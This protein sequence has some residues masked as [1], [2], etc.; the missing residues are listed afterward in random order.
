M[1]ALT[2]Q[3]P[4]LL[5]VIKKSRAKHKR[6]IAAFDADGTLWNTDLGE[7]L[8]RYQVDN[9]LLE[10]LPKDPW[11][12]YESLKETHSHEVA[13]LWL[14][15]INRGLSLVQVQTWAQKAVDQMNPVPVFKEVK[16]L[17]KDLHEM[18]AEVYIVTASIK[19]V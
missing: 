19:C 15:Q 9:K 5:D 7:A 2:E 17:I 10:G 4:A 14:A 13:Y 8:F 3:Y 12:H 1:K 18:G 11:E 16:T 6:A